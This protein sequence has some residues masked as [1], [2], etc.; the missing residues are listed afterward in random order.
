[1][2]LRLALGVTYDKLGKRWPMRS[3]VMSRF[4]VLA[5]VTRRRLI[6]NSGPRGF[7]RSRQERSQKEGTE[8]PENNLVN[9]LAKQ[10]AA[11]RS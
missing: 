2:P 4:A 7:R 1:M 9:Y 3:W 5:G 10:S 8:D 6:E 11:A